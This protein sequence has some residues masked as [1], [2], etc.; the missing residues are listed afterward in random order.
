MIVRGAVSPVHTHVLLSAPPVLSPA[1]LARSTSRAD[2][3]GTCRRN[4]RKCESGI[5]DNIRGLK[6]ISAGRWARST[7]R[8]SRRISTAGSGK[9]TIRVTRSYRP[10]SRFSAGADFRRLQCGENG[11]RHPYQRG[12]NALHTGFEKREIMPDVRSQIGAEAKRDVNGFASAVRHG[13]RLAET[14]TEFARDQAIQ[15]HEQNG[16]YDSRVA[17]GRASFTQ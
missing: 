2:R 16:R 3:A 11:C 7:K 5:A 6:G 15:G 9:K 8:R 17:L 13:R 1:K 4:S 12:V 10:L 14:S